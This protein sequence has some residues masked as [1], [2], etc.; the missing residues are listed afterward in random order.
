MF[1]AFHPQTD[2]Q[3]QLVNAGM[4]QFVRVFV[5]HQPDDGVES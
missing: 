5:N 1:K 3:T 4:E 2:G